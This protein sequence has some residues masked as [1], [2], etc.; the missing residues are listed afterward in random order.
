MSNNPEN[1]THH[2]FFT[3]IQLTV[4]WNKQK[5]QILTLEKV[6][7][8]FGAFLHFPLIHLSNDQPTLSSSGLVLK[9]EF[10]LSLTDLEGGNVETALSWFSSSQGRARFCNMFNAIA[11][12]IL[13][14]KINIFSWVENTDYLVVHLFG[15]RWY[16]TQVK[17]TGTWQR[18]QVNMSGRG[19]A[20]RQV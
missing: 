9:Q 14:K 2:S 1:V 20:E 3:N 4:I 5:Q 7:I 6:L 12:K 18:T 16:Q 10:S 11:K 13:S 8:M 17:T 19:A 15:L